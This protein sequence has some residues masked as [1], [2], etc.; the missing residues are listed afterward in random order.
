MLSNRV[1]DF[2]KL[3]VDGNN[4]RT[5]DEWSVAT[6]N[7]FKGADRNGDGWLSR[8]GYATTK[9]KEAKKPVCKR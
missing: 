2:R 1:K 3:D 6:R 9:P 4:L 7:G 5:F 8:E